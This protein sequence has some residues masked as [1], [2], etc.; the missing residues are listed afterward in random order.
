MALPNPLSSAKPK[1]DTASNAPTE[2][3]ADADAD[4]TSNNGNDNDNNGNG[5]EAGSVH[6]TSTSSEDSNDPSKIRIKFILKDG[7]SV[8]LGFRPEE[9]IEEITDGLRR[10][11]PKELSK[12]GNAPDSDRIRLICMGK[13]VLAPPD[14][15]LEALSMPIFPTHPT[16]V[17]VSVKPADVMNS[18]HH[19]YGNKNNSS[20]KNMTSGLNIGNMNI[21]G[22]MGLGMGRSGLGLNSRNSN[23]GAGGSGGGDG[24]GSGNRNGNSSNANGRSGNGGN[25]TG[26]NAAGS[27]ECCCIIS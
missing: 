22:G 9:T 1:A 13:G 15:S 25:G 8:E 24:S 11:W 10:H 5:N 6:S 18:P 4:A 19:K 14:A 26:N 7:V 2:N 23:T 17:N 21:G 27:G 12:D 3:D 16:P 20:F